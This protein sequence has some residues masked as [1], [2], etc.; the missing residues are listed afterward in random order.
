[1]TGNNEVLYYSRLPI[2]YSRILKN[3]YKMQGILV[4]SD[5]IS[6][7]TQEDLKNYFR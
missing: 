3:G 4:D 2:P 7:D 5:T 1:M 6:V